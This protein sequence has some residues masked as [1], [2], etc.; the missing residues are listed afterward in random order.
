[1]KTSGTAFTS[2]S[3][4][5]GHPFEDTGAAGTPKTLPRK[6]FVPEDQRRGN[7]LTPQNLVIEQH[8]HYAATQYHQQRTA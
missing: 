6:I 2:R 1:M 3:T 5:N 4:N 7:D 8:Q